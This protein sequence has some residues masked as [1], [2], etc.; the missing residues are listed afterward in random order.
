MGLR[1]I[2]LERRRHKGGPNMQ[3]RMQNCQKVT[4]CS[5]IPGLKRAKL[6]CR[7]H[8]RHMAKAK[9]GRRKEGS[10]N[11]AAGGVLGCV[12]RHGMPVLECSFQA[13]V[14]NL[15]HP[16]L[17]LWDSR[18]LPGSWLGFPHFPLLN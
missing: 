3:K 12:P 17:A 16:W 15:G 10:V 2:H 8:G 11:G 7:L 9:N 14:D 13:L 6:T 4:D 5:P 18:I 1:V